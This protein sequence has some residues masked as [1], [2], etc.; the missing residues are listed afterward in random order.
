[1]VA[2]TFVSY[3][4]VILKQN[5]I[6]KIIVTFAVALI[7]TLSFGQSKTETEIMTLSKK[8][9]K[10]LL[11]GNA[12]SLATIYDDNSMTVHGNGMIKSTS[13]HF[14]DIKNKRPIYKNI[15]IQESTV[16]DFGATA[17]LVGKGVFS[18]SI[19]G[20]DMVANMAYTEVY[21]K[22]GKVWKLIARH[23]SQI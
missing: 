16:K 15:E 6:M 23:A 21:L 13:E 2:Y 3:N 20:N 1:M 22:K 9:V 4:Q 5:N 19:N 12:D 17:V 8:R 10:W 18:I 7:A 11:E 14:E